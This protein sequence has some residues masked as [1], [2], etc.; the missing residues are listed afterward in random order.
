MEQ[1]AKVIAEKLNMEQPPLLILGPGSALRST[2]AEY[3]TKVVATKDIRGTRFVVLDGSSLHINPFQIV[4]NAQYHC[5][6][7]DNR[8]KSV[9]LYLIM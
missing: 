8:A 7:A 1:Y 9:W 3:W 2:V 6:P 4:R 5:P